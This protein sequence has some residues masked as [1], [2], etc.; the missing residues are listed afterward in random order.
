MSTIHCMIVGCAV[1]VV[2]VFV[3]A[4]V[5]AAVAVAVIVV[6]V[7]V[8]VVVVDESAMA[9][10]SCVAWILCTIAGGLLRFR[11][12]EGVRIRELSGKGPG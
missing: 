7:V 5:A 1:V 8:V 6:V 4:V 11:G 9:G 10:Q 12:A 2:V 3:A